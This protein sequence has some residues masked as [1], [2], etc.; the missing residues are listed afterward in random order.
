MGLV[1]FTVYFKL[2][3]HIDFFLSLKKTNTEIEI[4]VYILDCQHYLNWSANNADSLH[5]FDTGSRILSKL[6]NI[7]IFDWKTLLTIIYLFSSLSL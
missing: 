7:F 5:V 6:V 3:L 1:S 4:C 2:P